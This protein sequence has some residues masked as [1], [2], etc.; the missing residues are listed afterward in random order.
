VSQ[1]TEKKRE[2]QYMNI[3]MNKYR[4]KK[5]LRYQSSSDPSPSSPSYAGR[6]PKARAESTRPHKT[7][8][9]EQETR[10]LAPRYECSIG[11]ADTLCGCFVVW[12]KSSRARWLGGRGLGSRGCSLYVSLGLRGR[13]SRRSGGGGK[14]CTLLKSVRGGRIR[15]LCVCV[16]HSRCK[17]RFRST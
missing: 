14:R 17:G 7:H 12:W 1:H 6:P 9:L 16:S 13:G 2:Y 10:S 15:R 3:S 5:H 8:S 11:G 4:P